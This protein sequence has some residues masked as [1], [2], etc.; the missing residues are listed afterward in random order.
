MI[1]YNLPKDDGIYTKYYDWGTDYLSYFPITS[2][3]VTGLG[4][5]TTTGNYFY[6]P[7]GCNGAPHTIN[8][9]YM[10]HGCAGTNGQ[11]NS[12]ICS[13]NFDNLLYNPL[14]CDYCLQINYRGIP[15]NGG[16]YLCFCHR[17]FTYLKGNLSEKNIAFYC[18]CYCVGRTY[19]CCDF[20]LIYEKVGATYN[21][22]V[23]GTKI[24]DNGL[25]AFFTCYFCY[26]NGLAYMCSCALPLSAQV[27][28]GPVKFI[29]GFK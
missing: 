14:N 10:S 1:I 15:S 25:M 26:A 18:C 16:G 4:N 2:V 17:Y 24:A 23:D 5:A 12:F 20:T 13:I 3:T 8:N 11:N 7:K 9:F 21:I 28:A 19:T 29:K 22:Y 6:M 27:L